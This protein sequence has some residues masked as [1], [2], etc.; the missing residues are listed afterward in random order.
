MSLSE[1]AS[2]ELSKNPLQIAV[3]GP[4]NVG[5]TSLIR[6]LTRRS[7]F[8]RIAD[9]AGVTTVPADVRLSLSGA[10]TDPVVMRI[11]DTPGFEDVGN[12]RSTLG[13]TPGVDDIVKYFHSRDLR[14]EVQIIAT[15]RDCHVAIYVIKPSEE[16]TDDH[17]EQL[18]LVRS[19]GRPI[20]V[21]FHR[22]SNEK[23]SYRR[24]WLNLLQSCGLQFDTLT[25]DSHVFEPDHEEK[26]YTLLRRRVECDSSHDSLLLELVANCRR[27][28]EM[29]LVRAAAR[30]ARFLN[31]LLNLKCEKSGVE[32]HEVKEMQ[33]RLEMQLRREWENERRSADCDLLAIF[34]FNRACAIG[35]DKELCDSN[36]TPIHKNW[37]WFGRRI[38]WHFGIGT[39]MGVLMD[40]A[41]LAFGI[42][43]FF[44]IAGF[45]AAF[46]GGAYNLRYDHTCNRVECSISPAVLPAIRTTELERH[47]RLVK[48]LCHS[49]VAAATDG[50]L[51]DHPSIVELGSFRFEQY[52]ALLVEV[53][54]DLSTNQEATQNT[55][56]KLIHKI[57]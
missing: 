4:T 31:Y 44:T 39:G 51:Q 54:A 37:S 57:V 22:Y 52:P 28:R 42:P 6:S 12:A 18:F 56:L 36:P 25:I 30:I 21:V 10:V 45:L 43:P 46:G 23:R 13:A 40:I 11:F 33:E 5:K 15:L 20:I 38:R 17:H 1:G 8:G 19:T 50:T 3:I 16:P 55:M 9:T 32:K 41:G 27:N 49:G 47:M 35:E 53:K 48:Q 7:D 29:Q 14:H 24:N 26:F 2:E 34:D